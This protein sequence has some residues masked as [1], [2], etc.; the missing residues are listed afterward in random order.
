MFTKEVI[1]WI[2]IRKIEI[3][4]ECPTKCLPVYTKIG[5]MK[6]DNCFISFK[7]GEKKSKIILKWVLEHTVVKGN[8]IAKTSLAIILF[9]R[10]KHN[11][12]GD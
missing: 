11:I 7:L 8:N 1:W 6:S 12:R 3:Y 10:P 9:M 2:Q 4:T 5:S